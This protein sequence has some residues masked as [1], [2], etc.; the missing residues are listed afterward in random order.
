MKNNITTIRNI[1]GFCPEDAIW[2]MLIDICSIIDN[3]TTLRN[4]NPD[5]IIVD[6]DTFLLAETSSGFPEFYAPEH[7]EQ[8]PINEPQM[9]WS[10]GSLAYFMS[11]GHVI[12]GGRGGYY[13]REHPNV[14]LPALQKKHI[15]LTPIVQRCLAANPAERME[16]SKLKILLQEGYLSCINKERIKASDNPQTSYHQFVINNK[17]PEEMV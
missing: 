1:A 4:I 13:Q 17:W 5:S 15:R 2:K 10:L 8:D 6:G 12:F 14:P 11:S 9:V 3:K 16:L 7:C